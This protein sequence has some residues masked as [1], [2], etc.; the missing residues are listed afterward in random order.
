MGRPFQRIHVK[1]LSGLRRKSAS[2]DI[3]LLY[4][5]CTYI[6]KIFHEECDFKFCLNKISYPFHPYNSKYSFWTVYFDV[7]SGAT[8]FQTLSVIV[9]VPSLRN[10]KQFHKNHFLMIALGVF[11]NIM[12]Y[13]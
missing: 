12:K 5:W 3:L 10:L 4:K 2:L 7:F 13:N 6:F 8:I 11:S 1:Y 9:Y